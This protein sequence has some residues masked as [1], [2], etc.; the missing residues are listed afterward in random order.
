MR[1]NAQPKKAQIL[2]KSKTEY[3]KVETKKSCLYFV[4][5]V[6]KIIY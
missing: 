5:F 1:R 4:Y 3:Q 2:T 6:K